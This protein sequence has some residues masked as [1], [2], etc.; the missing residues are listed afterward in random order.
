MIKNIIHPTYFP[1]ISQFHLLLK[2]P[3]VMEVSDNY[4]KQTYRNRAYIYGANG[5]Q[6]LSVPIQ[7]TKGNNGRQLYKDVKVDNS[8]P[9]QKIH[10]KS[11][12]TAYQTTPYFEFYEDVFEELFSKKINFLLDLN[13][14]TIQAVLSCLSVDI[15]W[16]KTSE[17][18]KEYPDLQDFRFLTDAKKEWEIQ[19]EEYYQIFQE[20]H[21]FLSNLS[22]L[23]LLFHEGNKSVFYL[24]NFVKISI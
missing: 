19:Q 22:V 10:W 24:E 11:L 16:E 23:D 17:Y 3:C 15:Q 20:K 18:K 8:Y 9:W 7:H 6:L 14:E 21:G 12:K 4:Q 2:N 13:F 5:K 1:T